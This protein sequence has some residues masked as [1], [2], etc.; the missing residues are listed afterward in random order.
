MAWLG[1]AS[2]AVVVLKWV[3]LEQEIYQM[4]RT[5]LKAQLKE[6]FHFSLG[7]KLIKRQRVS[8]PQKKV[9]LQT[10]G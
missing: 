4:A 8:D 6:C 3:S 1:G 5:Y 9:I 10:A 2:L 7:M